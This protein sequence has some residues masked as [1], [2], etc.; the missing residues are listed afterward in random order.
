[1]CVNLLGC[2]RLKNKNPRYGK[3]ERLEVES[4]VEVQGFDGVHG[5]P[6]RTNE[7]RVSP[8]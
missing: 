1:M 2:S 4:L 5:S 6:E 7:R 8:V 3:L